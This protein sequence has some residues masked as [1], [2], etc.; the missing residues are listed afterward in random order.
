MECCLAPAEAC[1]PVKSTKNAKM[2]IPV[3][4]NAN[5][6]GKNV[7]IWLLLGVFACNVFSFSGV[8]REGCYDAMTRT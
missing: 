8:M 6:L 3:R 1:N 4:L 7:V 5:L 2:K